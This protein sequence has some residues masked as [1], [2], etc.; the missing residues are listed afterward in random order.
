MGLKPAF[1]SIFLKDREKLFKELDTD[2]DFLISRQQLLSYLDN[3]G[4]AVNQR[5]LDKL[6]KSQGEQSALVDKEDFLEFIQTMDSKIQRLFSLLDK[7]KKGEISTQYLREI[8]R[9]RKVDF[10]MEELSI[11]LQDLIG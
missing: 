11:L 7:E 2:L 8:L 10:S 4:L 3:Q 6:F 1:P 5:L 9:L